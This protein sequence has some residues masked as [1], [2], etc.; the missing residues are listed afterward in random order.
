MYYYSLKN[1]DSD[2]F[3]QSFESYVSFALFNLNAEK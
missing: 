2:T 3:W 1:P